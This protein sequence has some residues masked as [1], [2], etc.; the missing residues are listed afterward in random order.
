M[1]LFGMDVSGVARS[2]LLIISG[3][4]ITLLALAFAVYSYTRTRRIVRMSIER[5]NISN[6]E[7]RT[8][9]LAEG[10]DSRKIITKVVYASAEKEDAYKALRIDELNI[11]NSGTEVIR[12]V[13]IVQADPLSMSIISPGVILDAEIIGL[14]NKTCGFEIKIHENIINIKFDFLNPGEGAV[15]RV[16]HSSQNLIIFNG[17]IIGVSLRDSSKNLGFWGGLILVGS[18]GIIFTLGALIIFGAAYALGYQRLWRVYGDP[19]ANYVGVSSVVLMYLAMTAGLLFDPKFR[20]RF[21]FAIIKLPGG[22]FRSWMQMIAKAF[23]DD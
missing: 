16:A 20:K 21:P 15:I 14:T 13:N 19:I 18:S 9:R 2:P 5:R 11:V 3:Y 22:S 8:R 6:F 1:I 23:A 12:G 17:S 4:I 10:D 7:E